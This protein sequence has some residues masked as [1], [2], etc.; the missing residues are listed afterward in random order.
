METV[1]T[2]SNGLIS[3]FFLLSLA[4]LGCHGEGARTAPAG[5]ATSAATSSPATSSAGSALTPEMT[6]RIEVLIRS[7]SNVPPNYTIAVGQPTTSDVPGFRQ[8][9][10]SFTAD[11]KQSKPMNF[12]L[13]D[14]GKTLAQFSKY[15]I[16]KD[17]RATVSD[18]GRPARGGPEGAPVTI[19]GFDDLECP[20]CGKLHAQMFPALLERYGDQVRFVYKDFPLSMHPWAMRAAIDVNCLGLQ[21]VTGYWNVVDHIHA[22]AGELGGAEKS[23]ATANQA[24]DTIVRDEGAV[25]KVDMARLNACL[26]KQDDGIVQASIKEANAMGLEESTPVLFING[27]KFQGAYPN[28]D[29]FRMIDEALIAQG[30]TPPAAPKGDA[31]T[32]P[33]N[34]PSL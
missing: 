16:G 30:R 7:R 1:F 26:V 11:G 25:Q 18:A 34:K 6:R 2:A 8:V 12:L 21:S 13:S 33:T 14:D 24:L 3:F 9:S 19:V 4:P 32:P 17:P 31:A 22:H 15:D 20:F 29:L 23:L 27:E 28:E 5:S 10:V